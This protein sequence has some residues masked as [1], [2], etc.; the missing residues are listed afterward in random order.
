MPADMVNVNK[1]LVPRSE[2]LDTIRKEYNVQQGQ[3]DFIKMEKARELKAR[4]CLCS[5]MAQ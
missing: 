1:Q 3:I 4:Q 2:W 5:T